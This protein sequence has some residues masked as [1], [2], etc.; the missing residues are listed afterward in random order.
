[1]KVAMA[2]CASPTTLF[3]VFSLPVL[4]ATRRS[5]SLGKQNG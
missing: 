2:V 1:M 4:V 5:L 3:L